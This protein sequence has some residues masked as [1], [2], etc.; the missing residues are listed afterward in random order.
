MLWWS[1]L[2]IPMVQSHMATWNFEV[3]SHNIN[4]IPI[5]WNGSLQETTINEENMTEFSTR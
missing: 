4:Y 3:Q 1:F 5:V 2:N